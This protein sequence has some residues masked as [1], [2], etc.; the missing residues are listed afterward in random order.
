MEEQRKFR[1]KLQCTDKN[2]KHHLQL[3]SVDS[4]KDNSTHST[5]H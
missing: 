1:E 5:Q 4:G 2:E 3:H